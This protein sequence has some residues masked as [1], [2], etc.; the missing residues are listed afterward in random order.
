M[1]ISLACMLSRFSCVWLFCNPMHCSPPGSYVHE[2]LQARILEWIAMPSSRGSS[3]PRD[4]IRTSC[5]SCTSVTWEALTLPLK[6][7]NLV[8]KLSS[9]RSEKPPPCKVFSS[10]SWN[11]KQPNTAFLS[12]FSSIK[13]YSTPHWGQRIA[14][15]GSWSWHLSKAFCSQGISLSYF[16]NER[17]SVSLHPHP[18]CNP[19]YLLH[20]V[21]DFFW[22]HRTWIDDFINVLQ[23]TIWKGSRNV[24][25]GFQLRHLTGHEQKL[26]GGSDV[27]LHSMSGEG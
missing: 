16:V 18:P 7:I 22:L 10:T 5:V 17:K 13:K 11:S 20:G 19:C 3:W 9:L 24:Y 8:A 6:K 27:K 1:Q 26:L 2:T 21:N 14:R 25:E 15:T 4:Q 23:V 12:Q